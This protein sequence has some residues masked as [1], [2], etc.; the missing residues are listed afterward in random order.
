MD[1]FLLRLDSICQNNTWYIRRYNIIITTHHD[2]Y[3]T[4]EV[5]EYLFYI[6]IPPTLR[7]TENICEFCSEWYIEGPYII[8]SWGKKHYVRYIG[9]LLKKIDHYLSTHTKSTE[10]YIFFWV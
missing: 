8:E 9:I 4:G 3:L 5:T 7:L 2:E 10:Y 6:I 1:L